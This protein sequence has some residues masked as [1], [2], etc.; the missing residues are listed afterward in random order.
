M[1]N[2]LKRLVFRLSGKIREKRQR[3]ERFFVFVV[4]AHF[5]MISQI[6]DDSDDTYFRVI[7]GFSLE[8]RGKN[9]FDMR[10]S[11]S[12]W[13]ARSKSK[14]LGQVDTT[15]FVSFSFVLIVQ[16]G[17]FSLVVPFQ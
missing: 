17:A 6:F 11:K 12:S 15:L 2:T 3:Q 4:H 9:R 8:V 14:I 10:L 13:I 5:S 1:L 7:G 16:S